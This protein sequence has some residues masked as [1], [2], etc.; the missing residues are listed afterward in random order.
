M[1]WYN[2]GSCDI[3]ERSMIDWQVCGC[4]IL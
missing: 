4:A 3:I 1:L 2:V